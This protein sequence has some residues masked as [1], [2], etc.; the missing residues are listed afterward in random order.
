M[1]QTQDKQPKERLALKI[2]AQ[3]WRGLETIQSLFIVS[4]CIIWT[5]S[6][7]AS[8][9]LIKNVLFIIN[10]K[11]MIEGMHLKTLERCKLLTPGLEHS[12][13]SFPKPGFPL[14]L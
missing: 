1:L 11:Q 3:Q 9:T 12:S 5:V 6:Q 4:P 2:K 8:T 10:V 7:W 13:A 14:I